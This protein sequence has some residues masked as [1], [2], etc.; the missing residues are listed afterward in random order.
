MRK[1]YPWEDWLG[2]PRTVILRGVHYRCSQSSMAQNIRN[3]ASRRGVRV[4]VV[5]TNTEIT[6]EVKDD[7]RGELPVNS[8]SNGSPV[9]MESCP[10]P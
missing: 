5:D 7:S 8:G 9:Q 1:L 3:E 6:I 10:L 2:R 4:R